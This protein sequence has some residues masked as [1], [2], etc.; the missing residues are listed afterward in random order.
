M[1]VGGVPWVPQVTTDP[2]V[3]NGFANVMWMCGSIVL[4]M[5]VAFGSGPLFQR[6]KKYF[7]ISKGLSKTRMGT[8]FKEKFGL[9]EQDQDDQSLI[10]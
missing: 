10:L 3:L 7:N 5:L 2:N 4:L 8:Y 1:N 6:A 9:K